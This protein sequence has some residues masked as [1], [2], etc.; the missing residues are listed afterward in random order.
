MSLITKNTSVKCFCGSIKQA[1]RLILRSP[2][3]VSIVTDVR[4]VTWLPLTVPGS[5]SDLRTQGLLPL[6]LRIRK[7]REAGLLASVSC[8]Y[9][10][11]PPSRRLSSSLFSL[12][13][14]GIQQS[15]TS[16]LCQPYVPL[17]PLYKVLRLLYKH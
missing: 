2:S 16:S 10:T 6:S 17:H 12:V 4:S 3:L 8:I 9:T 5:G 7:R 11:C 14:L 1:Y 15:T 13:S